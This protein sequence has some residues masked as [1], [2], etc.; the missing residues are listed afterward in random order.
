MCSKRN[1]N[2]RSTVRHIEKAVEKRGGSLR[3]FFRE[4][5]S[6]KANTLD[7]KEKVESAVRE[8]LVIKGLG[9]AAGTH[10]VI[11]EDVIAHADQTL[12]TGDQSAHKR[13]NTKQ[14]SFRPSFA[15][16]G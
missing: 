13:K 14:V 7:F 9:A 12:G 16:G 10:Y 5:L 2:G 6:K 1:P 8:F 3:Q 11:H 15:T 4:A